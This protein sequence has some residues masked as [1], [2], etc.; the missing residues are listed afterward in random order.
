MK[1]DKKIIYCRKK[2]GLSQEALAEKLGVSRQAISKWETGEATPEISKLIL[3]AKTF[4]VSTDW[5]LSEDDPEVDKDKVEDKLD[6]ST[7][8][9]SQQSNKNSW[10]DSLPGILG[11]LLRRYGWLA[12]VYLA[13]VGSLFIGLGGWSRYMVARMFSSND[14]DLMGNVFFGDDFFQND[15]E[16]GGIVNGFG[17]QMNNTMEQFNKN[18][19]VSIMGMAFIIFGL[20]ILV[21]GIIIAM[22]LKKK[23]K[24]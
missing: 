1:I 6:D 18:N 11:R 23:S 15:F 3:I 7:T 24:E 22:V 20:V 17:S 13:I 8:F 16:F 5:L 4:G 2:E 21:A 19:P 10:I 14:S 9:T 12:G